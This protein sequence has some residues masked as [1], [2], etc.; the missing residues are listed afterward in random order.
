MKDF[1]I[2]LGFSSVE[3]LP[4]LAVEVKIT[5]WLLLFL[6]FYLVTIGI[7]IIYNCFIFLSG[8]PV[9]ILYYCSLCRY[10]DSFKGT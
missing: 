7:I 1:S 8:L 6:N 9:D 10:S 5:S 4:F 3:I 2:I